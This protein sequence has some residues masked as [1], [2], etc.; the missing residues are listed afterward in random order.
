M[1][2]AG[3]WRFQ[4]T[5]DSDDGDVLV[6]TGWRTATGKYDVTDFLVDDQTLN[7][8]ADGSVSA[9]G[10]AEAHLYIHIPQSVRDVADQNYELLKGNPR[11]P[12]LQ[13]KKVGQYWVV[14]VGLDEVRY[15]AVSPTGRVFDETVQPLGSP[16][17]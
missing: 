8:A 17:P 1:F 3:T 4:F 5:R 9:T 16:A 6:P 10:T 14:R 11:H 13:L 7:M 2:A 15:A 12:S